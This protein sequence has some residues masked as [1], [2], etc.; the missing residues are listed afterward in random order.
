[1]KTIMKKEG[2]GAGVDVMYKVD[3]KKL[4]IKLCY[5]T[6]AAE[7]AVKY[8]TNYE[9]F[10]FEVVKMKSE[11]EA[12]EK[13]GQLPAF[14]DGSFYFETEEEALDFVRKQIGM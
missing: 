1:M 14:V 11:I 8:T 2:R 6:K 9:N 7:N 13:I 12:P 10:A 3:P 4:S 5:T